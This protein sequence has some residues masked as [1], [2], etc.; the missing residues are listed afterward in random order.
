MALVLDCS[1]GMKT[2]GRKIVAS[3]Q[4]SPTQEEDHVTASPDRRERDRH[5]GFAA[6]AVQ[7]R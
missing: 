4:R 6:L 5:A 1:K 2:T 7:A 3:G